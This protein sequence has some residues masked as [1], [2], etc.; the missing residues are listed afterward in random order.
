MRLK[1]E[2]WVHAFL[3][4]GFAEGR[5]GAVL[6]KGAPEAGAVYVAVNRLDG[7]ITLLGPPPGPAVDE[8]GERR[9]AEVIPK[10]TTMEELG[11][12]T[13]RMARIDPD[14]W[15]VEIEDRQG[16]AGFKVLPS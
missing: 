11:K 4:R 3:R 15:I 6:R 10:I 2:M 5:Y 16:N 14:F 13:E 9:F 12:F 8:E 1:S 7:T